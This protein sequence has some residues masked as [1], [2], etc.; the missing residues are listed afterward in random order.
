M[1]RPKS[2]LAKTREPNWQKRTMWTGNNLDI[3]RG[4]NSA[5]ADL[6]YLAP[7]F[8]SN[9]T[10]SALIGSE[11]A[12]AAF[13]DT[14]TLSDVDEGWHGEVA[15]REPTIYAAGLGHG[16]GISPTRIITVAWF[17]AII[18]ALEAGG[19]TG[20]AC[21]ARTGM[22]RPTDHPSSFAGAFTAWRQNV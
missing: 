6:I 19:L 5:S 9:R 10:H 14:W 13:K 4:M 7:P 11:A 1:R 3:L 18:P 17:M 22:P 16:K 8:N 21:L 20:A 2:N 15:D 12:G